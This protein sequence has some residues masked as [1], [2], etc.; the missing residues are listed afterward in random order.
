MRD[1][2]L[3]WGNIARRRI[4]IMGGGVSPTSRP[5]SRTVVFSHYLGPGHQKKDPISE[6]HTSLDMQTMNATLLSTP[7]VSGGA[8]AKVALMAVPAQVRN[9]ESRT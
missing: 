7:I 8:K 5:M 6:P 3:F 1:L 9:A 2:R 4:Q